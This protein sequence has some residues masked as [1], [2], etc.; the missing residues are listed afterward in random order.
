MCILCVSI[1]HYLH[2]ITELSSNIELFKRFSREKDRLQSFKY[3]I[4]PVLNHTNKLL[5]SFFLIYQKRKD[6][7]SARGEEWHKQVEKTLKKIHQV[8]D[9]F[10]KENK[11][12]FQKQKKELEEMI[13]KINEICKKAT[14]Q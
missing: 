4:E 11:T 7:V 1:K 10:K 6:E 9:D 12:V 5:S 3:E 8:L 13:G 2:E 14:K